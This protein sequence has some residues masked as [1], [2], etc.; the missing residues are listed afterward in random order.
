MKYGKELIAQLEQEIKLL[1][2]SIDDRMGRIAQGCTDMDDCFLSQ[3]VEER[4]ITEKLNEIELIKNG[5][6]AWFIEYATLGGQLVN[7]RWCDTRYGSKLRVEMPDGSVVWTASTT[8]KGLEKRGL[9]EVNVRRPAWFAFR[10]CGGMAGVYSGS[11]VLVPSAVNY[12]TG[13]PAGAEP[14]EIRG[15]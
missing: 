13:E 15:I 10:S 2:E 1:R 7:A 11:Y 12:A 14:I 6:C 9:K 3:R 8:K 4:G 5:G